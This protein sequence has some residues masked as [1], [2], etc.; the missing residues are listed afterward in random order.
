MCYTGHLR[1]AWVAGA[2]LRFVGKHSGVAGCSLDVANAA[3]V[4]FRVWKK[5]PT[6]K[7]RFGGGGDD[8]CLTMATF[9]FE[10]GSAFTWVG[11]RGRVWGRGAGLETAAREAPEVRVLGRVTARVCDGYTYLHPGTSNP[12]R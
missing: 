12:V 9:E 4:K 1:G 7:T 11:S 2:A 6:W 5:T 10:D 3:Q 8:L